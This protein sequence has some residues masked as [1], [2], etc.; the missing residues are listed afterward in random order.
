[1]KK[2]QLS[3]QERSIIKN[4]LQKYPHSTLFGSRIKGTAK[5]F[6]DLDICLKDQIKAYEYE[7][8]KEEF[9]NSDLP[10][11]VDIVEYQ[12]LD[13]NFKKIIDADNVPLTKL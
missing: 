1:M 12:E 8:L 7:L 10:F 5:K 2:L 13:N 9:E 6:S 3:T 11:T 4:I